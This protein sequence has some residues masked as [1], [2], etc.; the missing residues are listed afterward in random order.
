MERDWWLP[1]FRFARAADVATGQGFIR[2]NMQ[3]HQVESDMG[4]AELFGSFKSG[5]VEHGLTLG[6]SHTRKEQDPI[7]QRNY[8]ISSQN[9]YEAGGLRR[10]Q[11]GHVGAGDGHPD[12]R[13]MND[14]EHR[15]EHG[16]GARAELALEGVQGGKALRDRKSVV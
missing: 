8:N 5:F 15:Q 16:H 11:L 12:D 1:I 10:R 4:R 2:G 7:Y 14:V 6:L 9:L 13:Q 3:N